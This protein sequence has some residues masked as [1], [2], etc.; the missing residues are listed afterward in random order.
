[1]AGYAK[2]GANTIEIA[3]ELFGSPNFGENIGELKGLESVRHGADLQSAT[4]INPWQIQRFPAAMRA[5]MSA[6]TKT[7]DI[8]LNFSVGGWSSS[9]LAEGGSPSTD[10]VPAFIWCRAEFT[11]EKPDE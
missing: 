4:A 3:Y 7:R 9:T 1:L 10:L 5:A 8:D 2:I 6:A 11:L